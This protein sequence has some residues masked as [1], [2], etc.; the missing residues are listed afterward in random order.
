MTRTR[1]EELDL[2][3]FLGHKGTGGGGSFLGNWKES[4]GIVVWLHPRAKIVPLWSHS[5]YRIGKTRD[6]DPEVWSMRFNSM[7]RES[8]LRRF[9]QRD[10]KT[11]E[12]K[13]PPE[14]CP[15]SLF[16]EWLHQAIMR[17]DIS[18]VDEIF[19]FD[20]GKDPVILHAGGVLGMFNVK[21]S[22]L[23]EEEKVE[24]RRARIR[25][26][27]AWKE[28]CKPR[29][30]YIFRVVQDKDPSAGCMVALESAALGDAVK[31]VIGDRIDDSGRQKGD[32]FTTPYAIKWAF[33][34][35]QSFS[36]KYAARPM[37]S[38]EVSPEIQEQFDKEPPSIADIT[39]ESNVL[40]LRQSFEAHWCLKSITPPWDEIF[41]KAEE[42]CAGTEAMDDPASFPFG[43][44]EPEG[45]TE[46][47]GFE[48]DVCKA[49]MADDEFECKQCG[50]V[51]DPKSGSIL[52]KGEW[53]KP[54]KPK[55]R[56]RSG[57]GK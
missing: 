7:E 48:C 38:L 8:V 23:T 19:A 6:G 5:W 22:E 36:R 51:Y 13:F 26:D 35:K 32:P 54:E 16:L 20:E 42:E 25:R 56:S 18:W 33:D 17:K 3:A 30:Q 45:E 34:D 44:N 24:L 9:N 1:A 28:S 10:E 50:T 14:L 12:R 52:T 49:P 39:D 21:D 4:G 2:D 37:L 47:E 15:F 57:K 29:L 40:E 53:P 55:S 31:S 11:D 43:A 27:E 46:D 41:A